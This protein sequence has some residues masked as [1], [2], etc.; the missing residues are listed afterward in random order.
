MEC[1]D[2]MFIFSNLNYGELRNVGMYV[3]GCV[4]VCVF[5]CVCVCM[6]VSM[7]E[8]T[9]VYICIMC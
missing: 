5:T 7:Y 4:Y 8:C 2:E 9:Y 1:A 3:R 6:Y